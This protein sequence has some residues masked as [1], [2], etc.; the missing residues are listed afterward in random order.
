[1]YGIMYIYIYIVC[2][3][4]CVHTCLCGIRMTRG[5]SLSRACCDFH[6]MQSSFEWR[7][8][9]FKSPK[10]MPINAT[11]HV[12]GIKERDQLCLRPKG[13]TFSCKAE[14]DT[15]RGSPLVQTCGIYR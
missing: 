15:E 1:M 6:F 14:D 13:D 8:K 10:G 2:V 9:K 11:D 5:G 4:V 3:C 7:S 12:K